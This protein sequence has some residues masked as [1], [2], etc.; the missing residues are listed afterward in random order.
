MKANWS[1]YQKLEEWLT[2]KDINFVKVNEYQY[3]IMGDV[4]LVDV[5]PARMSVHIVK[6]EGTDPD[7]YMRLDYNFNGKQ[8]EKLLG[9]D[10]D[11]L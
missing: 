9:G 3:R 5:W 7:R 1:N 11:V 8:L 2:S 4:A 10:N 6:T